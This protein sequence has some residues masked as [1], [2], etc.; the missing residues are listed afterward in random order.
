MTDFIYPE[1]KPSKFVY[2][3]DFLSNQSTR[4]EIADTSKTTADGELATGAKEAAMA[5][6]AG[7]AGWAGA[8]AAGALAAPYAAAATAAG[9]PLAGLAVEGGAMLVGG[10]GGSALG[11]KLVQEG[12]HLPGMQNLLSTIGLSDEQRAANAKE[13]PLSAYAGQLAGQT[14]G[15][16]MRPG[17]PSA[18]GAVVG[19]SLNIGIEGGSQ[20]AEGK[21]DPNKLGMAAAAGALT[22]QIGKGKAPIEKPPVAEP[23]GKLVSTGLRDTATGEVTPTG[24][25]H[26]RDAEGNIPVGKEAVF[27][28]DKGEVLPRKE[29]A[30]RAKETSQLTENQKLEKPDEGLHSGDLREAG[31]PDFQYPDTAVKDLENMVGININNKMATERVIENRAK[32][33]E[34][35]APKEIR[36]SVP[37]AIEQGKIDTLPPEAKAIAEKYQGLV[38]DIGDRAVK[39]GV[40]S[41]LLEDYVTHIVDWTKA[42]KSAT[43]E[44][45]DHLITKNAH[46]GA[47]MSAKSQ[48]GKERKYKT[49]DELQAAIK[50]SGLE[51]KTKDISEIY[52]QYA[53]SMEKAIENR[54]LIDGIKDLKN[55]NGESLVKRITENEPKPRSWVVFDTPQFRGYAI[56]PDLAPALKFAFDAR[57][58]GVFLDAAHSVTQ[59]TKRLN[60]VGSFFHAK[61]LLEVAL[62]STNPFHLGK[63]LSLAAWDKVFK[64]EHAGIT[65]ALNM[66]RTGGLGDA[67]DGWLKSGLVVSMPEDVTKGLMGLTGKVADELI[68]K[69]GPKTHILEKSLSMAERASLGVFDKI[70][71]DYLHTGLKLSTAMRYMEKAKQSAAK[72]GAHFDEAAQQKEITRFI[73][74]S[75]GG[76]NWFD[77]ATQSRTELGKRMAMAA[78]NPNGRKGL[79]IL[80][81]A[82]DWTISTIRAFTEALPKSINPTKWHPIEGAKGLR[83]PKTQ[84]DYARL[85]QFKTAVTYLTLLNGINMLVGGRPIWQNKDPT[86]IEDKEGHSWQ[87]MKHAMEPE[88]WIS[89]PDKTLAAKLGF[90]PRITAIGLFGLEYAS[91]Y[92]PKLEDLSSIGRTKA[93]V[94]TVLPFQAQAAAKAPAGERIGRAVAGT[95]GVPEYGQTAQQKKQAR[96]ALAKR[97]LESA[98]KWRREHPE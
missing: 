42:G 32:E 91:P 75:F 53:K 52:R 10:F 77:V 45:L 2:P 13:N 61:S 80:M 57:D 89:S 5:L 69:Y 36:E 90:L 92:S 59:I 94:E 49:F 83:T 17:I 28:S 44:L 48:Y 86:R 76:L 27:V 72:N 33:L 74:N 30:V 68:G 6:P 47:G 55:V 97:K 65:K 73:N 7:A 50:D 67:V 82:P 62:N 38:K 22:K 98:R 41:G 87:A 14:L 66:Y 40:L 63:E 43:G 4:K 12:T 1:D 85:Y 58:T 35:M 9:G 25:K 51:V 15:G 88:Q 95:L 39:Q 16:G 23:T 26:P 11:Q 37:D 46:A 29:A 19:A 84:G 78:Y 3:E 31:E 96:S 64:T 54:K 8:T 79:Q 24:H 18:A 21:F 71:W 60:V 20:L 34:T 70:T 93:A 81:F 56:H